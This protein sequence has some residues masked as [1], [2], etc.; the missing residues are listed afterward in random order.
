NEDILKLEVAIKNMIDNFQQTAAVQFFEK[1]ALFQNLL[2]HMKPAYYRIKYHIDINNPL[3]DEIIESYKD[4]YFLT[5]K[6]SKPVQN[7][8]NREI[9]DDELAYITIHF[10]GWLKRNDISVDKRILRVLLVCTNG[11]G[12]SRIMEN[13][14]IN[15]L[16]EYEIVS[17]YSENDYN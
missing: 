1:D 12:T 2:L 10:G 6:S 7:M 17:L 13:Q 14:M 3:K 9:N 11:I 15:L 16:P 8:F 4:I 5:K